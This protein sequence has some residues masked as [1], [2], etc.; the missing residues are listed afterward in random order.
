MVVANLEGSVRL[1]IDTTTDTYEQ[2]I[3]AVR[4]QGGS[5][6]HR[7]GQH[8]PPAPAG[9]ASTALP[10]RRRPRARP[11]EGLRHGRRP[12]RP[13]TRQRSLPVMLCRR[14]P[15]A[16]ATGRAG[17][18]CRFHAELGPPLAREP[19][20]QRVA[21]CGPVSCSAGCGGRGW[22]S[23]LLGQRLS[24]TLNR[25]CRSPGSE[26][27]TSCD[28]ADTARPACTGP[29]AEPRNPD[30]GDIPPARCRAGPSAPRLPQARRSSQQCLTSPRLRSGHT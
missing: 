19:H 11:H 29:R 4:C 15:V 26:M 27:F 17:P 24:G 10:H 6:P 14:A 20:M 25:S 18:R 22:L 30:Y 2:A 16:A 23:S 13:A 9:R 21:P 7:P 8:R 28:G 1:T 5:A 12:P 3:A